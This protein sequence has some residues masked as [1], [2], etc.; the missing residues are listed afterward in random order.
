MDQFVVPQGKR[1]RLADHDPTATLGMDEAKAA[2]I[3]ERNRV[4]I[5]ELQEKLYAE[6]ERTLLVILQAMDTG[7]KDPIIRDVLYLANPQACR[8]TAFK[9]ATKQE[10]KRDRFWRFHLEMPGTGEI[11]VFNR[12]YYDDPIQQHAHDELDET[13]LQRS[14][15]QA[16]LFEQ[17]LAET[18][19]TIIKLFLHM[20]KDEQKRRIKNR[21]EDPDRQWELS[22]SDFEERKFWDGYM[23]AYESAIRH[24]NTDW[25][26]WYVIPSDRSWFRDA[27]ASII[28]LETLEQMNPQYPPPEVDLSKVEL[29]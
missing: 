15:R 22:K 29:V 10:K 17:T 7:G 14:Y 27:A 26:P 12:A 11:G 21:M 4:R 6:G 18:D 20:S 5:A 13:A 28:I 1:F 16:N 24:T 2:E 19:I 23:T 3:L 9:R 25:A 8:V